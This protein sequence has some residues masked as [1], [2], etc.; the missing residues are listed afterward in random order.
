M[1]KSLRILL[2]FIAIIPE[3]INAQST[4]EVTSQDILISQA[5]TQLDAAMQPPEGDIYKF[6]TEHHIRGNFTFD[7]TFRK[8]GEMATVY[9]VSSENASIRM[10]NMLKDHLKTFRFNIKVPKKQSRKF[11]YTFQF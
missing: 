8:K 2:L 1:T 3:F 4:N 10:Q 9:V 6:A 5:I 7:L 11:R